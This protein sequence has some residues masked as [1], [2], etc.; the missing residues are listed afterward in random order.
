MRR[1]REKESEHE[2]ERRTESRREKALYL[3]STFLGFFFLFFSGARLEK[4]QAGFG[5]LLLFVAGGGGGET[6]TS[7]VHELSEPRSKGFRFSQK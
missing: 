5:F 4:G 2:R 3:H 7:R 1:V 6:L